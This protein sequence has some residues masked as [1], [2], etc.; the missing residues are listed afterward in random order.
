[1][2]EACN[3]GRVSSPNERRIFEAPDLAL[4]EFRC[5][6]GDPQWRR[7]NQT[8]DE[9][10]LVV[11][12]R[13]TVWIGQEGR[14][15]VVA[16]ASRAIL[17]PRGQRYRRGLLSVDGDRCSFVALVPTL[18][19]DVAASFDGAADDPASYRFPFV[20]APVSGADYLRHQSI[21]RR[22]LLSAEPDELR[23]D[24]Y[25]LVGRVIA[26]GY[27]AQEPAAHRRRP[28]TEQ[29]HVEAVEAVR[30][31][32]G[33]DL[34]ARLP[35]DEVGRLVHLSPFHLSR[36]FRQRTGTSLHAYRTDLRLRASLERM[37]DG[38]ALAATAADLGFASQA[39]F[40]D[41]FRRAFGLT[42]QAWRAG[43]HGQRGQTSTNMKAS[44]GLSQIA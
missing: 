34:A 16:D 9:T 36:V 2:L 3:D 42:P 11:F 1:L 28:A 27:R 44:T 33:S 18:A 10:L 4:G 7:T 20:A 40:T 13:T 8:G 35:L 19:A 12:P 32:L 22:V 5:L 23:E 25:W 29:A 24:L 31:I 15:E 41:R 14:P 39:H 26:A 17:Y 21:R 43:V 38:I 6:P 30:V 37:A